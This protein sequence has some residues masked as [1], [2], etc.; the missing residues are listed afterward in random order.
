MMYLSNVGTHTTN[1]RM[2]NILSHTWEIK[3]RGWVIRKY[4]SYSRDV[5]FECR[6]EDRLPVL[7]LMS[8]VT[9][10]LARKSLKLPYGLYDYIT[11]NIDNKKRGV[12]AGDFSD[13]KE[14]TQ[15]SLDDLK[16]LVPWSSNK[17]LSH[18]G[19]IFPR[20]SKVTPQLTIFL[21]FS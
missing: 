17:H 15:N 14:C 16:T 19:K 20:R 8:T 6:S 18:L 12:I 10:S 1:C 13:T 11:T 9:N 2:A 5:V 4:S 21:Y 7:I 3:R